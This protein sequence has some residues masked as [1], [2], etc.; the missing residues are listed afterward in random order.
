[1]PDVEECVE[2]VG[3]RLFF[4]ADIV[5]LDEFDG[6]GG[7]AAPGGLGAAGAAIVGGL[8]AEERDSGSDAYAASLFAPVSIPPPVFFSFGI[9]PAKMPPSCG[10]AGAAALALLPLLLGASL[11]ALALLFGVGSIPGT[12]GAPPTGGPEGPP[13]SFPTTGAERSFVTAFLSCLPFCI[14][15]SSAPLGMLVLLYSTSAV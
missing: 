5:G 11:L 9:P 8:G 4:R 15:P 10:A 3:R 13:E 6:I 2:G 1:M 12:G 14:S 7:A